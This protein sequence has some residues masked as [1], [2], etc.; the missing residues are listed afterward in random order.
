MFGERKGITIPMYRGSILVRNRGRIRIIRWGVI[1]I[2]AEVPEANEAA[3][4]LREYKCTEA[5]L[6][7]IFFCD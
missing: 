1:E 5:R 4:F 2:Q 7:C 6:C 3:L